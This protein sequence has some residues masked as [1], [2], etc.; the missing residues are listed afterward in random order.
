MYAV[1][2]AVN[3]IR[4][5]DCDSA[6]VASANWIGDPGVQIALDKLGALSA[7]SRCHTFDS[8]AQGYARGEGY[9][10]IYI[11]KPSLAIADKSPIRAFIRGTAINANGRT[12]GITRPSVR[13]Q[14]AVIREAYRHAGN[15]PFKDTT[16]FECHGTG[17]YVGDPI[18]TAAVGNVFASVRGAGDPPLLVGSVKSNIG[19]SEGASALASIMKV[20]L[21]LENG[22]IPPIF[23]LQTRNPNID[24]DGA[25]IEP[26]TEVIP[27]P[28]G[29]PQRASINS[30]GYGGA[31]AHCIVD[32]VNNVLP[33]YVAPG[34][35]KSSKANGITNGATHADTNGHTNGH[36][37]GYQNGYQEGHQNGHNSANTAR[38]QP[39]VQSP[40]LTPK[41][42][43]A[44][45][46]SVLLPL[47]A[48][49]E[50]SLRL[51][52]D[53]LS[54]TIDSFSLADVAYTLSCRRSRLAQRSFCIV[55]K[56]KVSSDGL[57][58]AGKPVRAPLQPV[59]LGFIFTGQGAQWHGMGSGLFEYRVFR[60]AVE[61][62][63]MILR[64]LPNAPA[65]SLYGVLSGTCDADLVQ[66]AEVSQAA[67]TALQIGIVD[68]LASWSVRPAGVAGHSSGEIAAAYA[69][70]RITAAEAIVAAYKRGQ[71]V[72]KN[73]KHGAMLAV[74]LG[75][76]EVVKH[77]R[78]REDQVKVAAINSPGSVTLSG[79]EQAVE[80]VSEAMNAAS[81][82]NRKLKTSGNAYH[83]HHMIPIG[84]DYIKLLAQGTRHIQALGLDSADNRRQHSPWVS[85]VEPGMNTAEIKDMA[86]YWR[87][88]LESPVRFS[89]AV[90][91]LVGDEDAPVQVLVEIGPHPALKSPLE[92]I[93]KADRAGKPIAYAP[94]LRRGQD[95][96]KALLQLAGQLFNL[97][98]AVDLAAVNAVDVAGTDQ[99][100]LE[101]GCMCPGL[102]P[103]RY[104]YGG[105]NYHES[106]PSKE[107]RHRSVLRHDLLG[108]K[109]V[110][111]ARLRPQWR[112]ILRVKDVPWLSDHR[113]VP[114][115]VLP[116]AAY[117]AMAVEAATRIYG[118][119]SGGM[120]PIE[121]FSL[122]DVSMKRA[123]I[124][125]EDDYGVEM[126]TSMELVD[127]ATE[128]SPAWATFSISSMGRETSEWA[129]H[130]TGRVKVEARDEAGVKGQEGE[131][132]DTPTVPASSRKVS[133]RDWYKKFKKIGLGYGP[134]FRPLSRISTTAGGASSDLAVATVQL[135]T[136]SIEGGESRYPLHPASLDGAIQ[137]G[138]IAS[139]GGRPGDAKNAYVP[140][141]LASLYLS[142]SIDKVAGEDGTCTAVARGEMRGPRGANLDLQ[143]LGPG[144]EV[145]LRA[146]G[147]R[148]VSYPGAARGA[149]DKTA[150]SSP[151]T[152][153]VWRPDVH[154]LSSSQARRIFPP[155]LDNVKQSSSWGIT[156]KLAHFVVLSVYERFGRSQDGEKDAPRPSGEVGHFLDWIR[157]RGRDDQSELMAE[158]RRL[159]GRGL[160]LST[161]EDLAAQA[162]HV[163]EVKIAKLLHDNMA[164][165]L[166]ERRTGMDVIIGQGLLTP[167]YQSGLLM[168]GIYPQ[169]RRVLSGLGH[170]DPN[171][172]I[173]EIGGGTG[174]ATRVAMEALGGGAANGIKAYRDYTFTDISAGFLSAARENMSGF[175]DVDFS[176]LDVEADPLAQGH[177]ENAY[178][179][180]VA[181]QVLH[182]TSD[183]R[184]TLTNCRR[185]L[186]RGGRLVMVETTRNVT[187]PGVV[188]GT[189][190]GYWAGIPD[191]RVDSPFQG[192]D[193][194]DRSL[195]EAGFSGLDVVLDDFP[196][197]HNTTSVIVSTVVDVDPELSRE[198]FPTAPETDTVHVLHSSN[199]APPLVENILRE[200]DRR[201]VMAKTG[202]LEDGLESLGPGSRVVALLDDEHLLVNTSEKA[203]SSWQC[204]ARKASCLVA[205]TSCG[206]SRGRNP[207]GAVIPGLLRVLQNENPAAEYIS[208]DVDAQGFN[209]GAGEVEEL[210]R[211]VVDRERVLGRGGEQQQQAPDD[212]DDKHPRDAE[213]SWQD[214]CMWVG[215]HVPDGGFHS[216]HG[217]DSGG[218]RPELLPLGSQGPVRAAFETP[219][220]PG[221]LYF[222]PYQEL[223]QP[224]PR[225][226]FEVAISAVGLSSQDLDV[227]AGR[228]D[229]D[230]L[231][232]EYAGTVTAVGSDVDG[233]SVGD[234]VYGLGRGQFGTHA[235]V[236]AALAIKLRDG[237]DMA[238][239]AS[240]PVAF[241]TAVYALDHVARLRKGQ[242]V[243]VYPGTGSFGLAVISLARARGA[244]VFAVV[245]T[246]E[247]A[248]F[249]TDDPDVAMP[250][251]H[252]IT[253]SGLAALGRTAQLTGKGKFNV[254][255]STARGE[256]FDLLA[257]VLAPR[258]HLVDV[259]RAD[260]RPTGTRAAQMCLEMLPYNASYCSLDLL[261]VLE[262]DPALGAELMQAVDDLYRSGV[263]G[264]I[265][266]TEKTDV[267]QVN[268]ALAGLTDM[269]AKLVV[270]F[271]KSESLVRM[272]PPGPTVRLDPD[273]CYVLTGALGG[274]GQSLVRWMVGR[275]AR[276]LALL[277]RRHVSAVPEAQE[278]VKSL[279]ARGIDVRCLVCDVTNKDELT[280]AIQDMASAR[281]IRGVVHAAV[282]Y[283]DLTFDK[284]SPPRWREA[285][286]AKVQG[287]RNLHEATLGLPLDFFVMTTSALSVYAFPTQGAYAAANGFQD[288]F[289]RYR[290]RMGLPASAVSFGLVT[291]A[292][293]VGTSDTTV[294]LFERN[295][296]L[297]VG[298]SQFLG[299]VEPAF[300]NNRTTVTA[301][302]DDAANPAA[303]SLQQ[304]PGQDDDP[305][306]AA[307]LHAY[308]DPA[309]LLATEDGEEGAD[310]STTAP[311]WHADGRV[312]P[313]M[314]ALQDAR[315]QRQRQD[316]A[317]SHQHG[318]G[319]KNSAASLR[320]QFDAAIAGTQE[321]SN[322]STTEARRAAAVTLARD[323]I[324][325]AVADMLFVDAEGIDPTRSVADLGVDSLIAAEL[326]S[327]FLQALG[328]DVS[329]L[330][331]LD[332]N[333]DILAR[334]AGIA[335]RAMEAASKA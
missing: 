268:A 276:H 202:S 100:G 196:E 123:L 79:E 174:G 184:R 176:V 219:G 288:A 87:A 313:L 50:Q 20:V 11:K 115:A 52:L 331:L 139:H 324:V 170:A 91:A 45:R 167:L 193:A 38:Q 224:L 321:D 82:F 2:L 149:V 26:V 282:S 15:L 231:S 29:R 48:H 144:G 299:L 316:S 83:S 198:D 256:A 307:N 61:H 108:S 6:I 90:S 28:E 25:K 165:I 187:V 188:V 201:G 39:L 209:V 14:E 136:T 275:G 66:T 124:V 99:L 330:D 273:A 252:V 98:A 226:H 216:R 146:E 75:P 286:A 34:V 297:T 269:T 7:S 19:H 1:H 234:R 22:A 310:E 302:D 245:D 317:D 325:R 194:W 258:G 178:D 309:G 329:M 203:F 41:L 69:S 266:G 117:V 301:G 177:G 291:E 305:L 96:Q 333:V 261:S 284:L 166:H 65:W 162:S 311:R 248:S 189:F 240:M 89:E 156:N 250:A 3:A 60:I 246:V 94:T 24:F 113:L 241:A 279:E 77:I 32:H 159:S 153:L 294:R 215:R 109:V 102:P 37:N 192:L 238:L 21:A 62:L 151:F 85:S 290:R 175:R 306:S 334:A 140:V 70:G 253:A 142:N 292:T 197:P 43:A 304:W 218:M 298:E 212:V 84:G 271:E 272:A 120:V 59:N 92:Q 323:A 217:T 281:S 107:Y 195:R 49:N 314:R 308:L 312:S 222:V 31:N 78:G 319:A 155:P 263:I 105:I 300:L 335:D 207:D 332:P 327:W 229:G 95:G 243:L 122:A 46:Q 225:G 143:M 239:M 257:R 254:I 17:T 255:V 68:L 287:T 205:L 200:L 220:V 293:S 58:L 35:F 213:F 150:F 164:D 53:A 303:A 283:L 161:I 86:S 36:H 44:T 138:L 242:S 227:W 47:S 93:L 280:S 63:D 110:G 152:R 119:F 127:T 211:C 18:E 106:R 4:A 185:L 208:V 55:D 278:L 181:C 233:F 33:D 244:D 111:T 131:H 191:G 30:F 129:E 104:T 179:L 236:P 247:R 249:L 10:A 133:A 145:L 27:W 265:P 223:L 260:S 204:L 322:G 183:M 285:L 320:R 147:L 326:R 9:G 169:L 23:D 121:G 160:L 182:A 42:N 81:I 74:G 8:R 72:A 16:Y 135:H 157:R 73:K 97:N 230:H 262:S 40:R 67:C 267:A 221:S 56:D 125:P 134:A 154:A 130:C 274:L 13:G 235:A 126:V 259:G 132:H 128:Q 163:V 180:V 206:V 76:D 103:Y 318:R 168:T 12:G 51:N 270:S 80:E 116:G 118:E 315:R 295:R 277:S 158:A 264:P 64:G 214:G 237:D 186:A 232:S 114:D 173:L 148:C 5:G 328:A 190:T 289:A 137:L 296:T 210:A 88:N 101:H 251:P 172:R 199:A 228:A 54:S 141:H 171:L 57:E 112:N 71:A